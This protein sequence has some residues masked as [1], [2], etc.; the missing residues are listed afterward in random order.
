MKTV[1]VTGGAGFVGSALALGVKQQKPELRVMA[2]D[3]LRRRGSELNLPRLREGGVDF[4]HG[5]IRNPE[6]LEDA[7]PVDLI[8]ECSAEPSVLAGYGASPGY[9]VNTNLGGTINCLEVARKHRAAMIFLST[10]RVYPIDPLNKLSYSEAETRF[11]LDGEQAAPGV[12]E[13]GIS[14]RF[15]LEGARSLYGATKLC[16]EYILQEYLHMYDLQGLINRCGVITGPWQ[17]GKV[18]QGV[19]VLWVARHVFGGELTYLG[20]GGTGKQVRDILHVDD[21]VKLVLH[22]IDHLPELTG[23]IFNVGGGVELSLS[24]QELTALCRET[25]GNTIPMGS[26]PVDREADIRLYITDNSKVTEQT[27]WRPEKGIGTIL[28]DITDWV[29]SN[30]SVLGPILG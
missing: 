9:V 10:S 14:E 15:P 29:R 11:A 8:L 22:Q 18:D 1:L 30:E 21:L 23:E 24:L 26:D 19:V 5:D 13:K 7:G 17:M 20:Y 4:L 3:N 25:T 6:D 16:S 27:G 12:S 2:L 28:E